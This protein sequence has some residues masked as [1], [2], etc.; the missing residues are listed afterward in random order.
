MRRAV[1]A[2]MAVMLMAVACL[3]CLGGKRY[4]VIIVDFSAT[5]GEMTVRAGVSGSAGYLRRISVGYD[6]HAVLVDFYSTFGIN[7]PSGGKD[8]FVIPLKP[9]SGEICFNSGDG[10]CAVLAKGEDGQWHR[11][12][13]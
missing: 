2:A 10:Y 7:N 9:E 6:E 12:A 1:F 13:R 5:D 8:E 11:C 3:L 4:D